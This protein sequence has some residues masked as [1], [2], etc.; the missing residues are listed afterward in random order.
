MANLMVGL[1]VRLR[2]RATRSL[3]FPP[4]LAELT[5]V[6]HPAALRALYSSHTQVACIGGGELLWLGALGEDLLEAVAAPRDMAARA[7]CARRL[8]IGGRL[9]EVVRPGSLVQGHVARPLSTVYDGS[10]LRPWV[11]IGET[12]DGAPIAAPLN[13][14]SNPK[15]FTPE[16]PQAAMSFPGN[17][18]DARL[19]LAH[20][21][22]LP[23]NVATEG[24]VSPG[25]TED[26]EAAIRA[27]VDAEPD[28]WG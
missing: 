21:W 26:V 12:V 18:K 24:A 17:N 11:I 20:L 9:W 28:W 16:I 15:W 27:Y 3:R 14:P 7:T 13:E 2:Q 5:V 6:V 8:L 19:E 22:T 23:A 10:A 1:K 4:P 25:A